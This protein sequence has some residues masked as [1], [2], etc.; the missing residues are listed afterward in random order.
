[1]LM[2]WCWC[3]SQEEAQSWAPKIWKADRDS[4]QHCRLAFEVD[5][6]EGIATEVLLALPM[7]ILS[8]DLP[9]GSAQAQWVARQ[10]SLVRNVARWTKQWS[11]YELDM[12]T[13]YA[14]T[15]VLPAM[16]QS[17]P[18]DSCLDLSI[19]TLTTA[20][21]ANGSSSCEF[22]CRWKWQFIQLHYLDLVNG[23]SCWDSI[24][25]I[26]YF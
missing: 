16:H 19:R 13:L 21:V 10:P 5:E 1:M 4:I 25:P 6:V 22:R 26:R 14:L 3:Y 2:W 7:K 20:G 23:R 8:P 18:T 15:S 9:R 12:N 24:A 11:G 17:S